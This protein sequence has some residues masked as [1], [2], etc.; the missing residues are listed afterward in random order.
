MDHLPYP[1]D[2]VLPPIKIPYLCENVERYDG[3]GFDNFALRIGWTTYG[4]V[5][6]WSAR[7]TARLQSWLYF[8]LL[9]EIFGQAFIR[10]D[11]IGI[12]SD[13]QRYVTTK[14]LPALLKESCQETSKIYTSI[15][16][17]GFRDMSQRGV[18]RGRPS[19][20]F[21]QRSRTVLQLAESQSDVMD[22]GNAEARNISLSIKILLWSIGNAFETYL[23]SRGKRRQFARQQSQLLRARMLESGRCP[24][25]TEIYLSTYSPAMIYYLSAAPTLAGNSNHEHCS[26]NDGCIAHDVDESSYITRH[27]TEHCK[28]NMIEPDV[29][30]I[31]AIIENGGIPLI[32]FETLPSG[33]LALDVVQ[34]KYRLHYTAIS[35]V[36]SAG[37]GNPIANSLPLCQI[38]KIRTGKSSS[39]ITSSIR[40]FHTS[41]KEP[42][43]RNKVCKRVLEQTL[44][45][46]KEH[47]DT[48]LKQASGL[49]ARS[50]K[51]TQDFI[52][53]PI[54]TPIS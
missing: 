15:S 32:K 10:D 43:E 5:S 51:P 7:D 3:Q 48:S 25:W 33:D 52:I 21:N 11:F 37:L 53:G 9:E 18:L 29:Q 16:S 20:R 28:C 38:Q 14:K 54:A 39:T 30:K 42:I 27:V 31:V 2:A 22:S 6:Q 50:H 23:P 40:A 47:S 45:S 4:S 46:S 34:A 24:Y 13:G 36:W 12:A 8:G 49:R 1:D 17:L 26:A 35:H 41:I 19:V 44:S